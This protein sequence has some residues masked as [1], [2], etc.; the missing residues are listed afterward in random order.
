MSN[1]SNDIIIV[2]VITA[3]VFV[4]VEVAKHLISL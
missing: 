2:T 1:N 3:Y 4:G